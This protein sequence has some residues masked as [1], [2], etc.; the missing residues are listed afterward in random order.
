MKRKVEILQWIENTQ[1]NKKE[2]I[3]RYELAWRDSIVNSNGYRVRKGHEND[4]M[5]MRIKD[6]VYR[7]EE[8]FLGALKLNGSQIDLTAKFMSVRPEDVQIEAA[9]KLSSDYSFMY[10]INP[11]QIFL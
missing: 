6:E 2:T 8:V 1:K 9:K 3:V 4:P 7:N 10:K 11:H 5:K